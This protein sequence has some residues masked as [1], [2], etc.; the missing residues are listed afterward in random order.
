LLRDD[1]IEI[2]AG[3]RSVGL[4]C[5]ESGAVGGGEH[6]SM[7]GADGG[8]D[9]GS[10]GHEAEGHVDMARIAAGAFVFVFDHRLCFLVN[11]LG[12]IEELHC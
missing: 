4:G 8:G 7:S 11:T 10:E 2:F 12:R 6:R 3:A 5:A 1:G 9:D